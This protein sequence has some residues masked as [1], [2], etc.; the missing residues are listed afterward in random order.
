MISNHKKGQKTKRRVA[1]SPRRKPNEELETEEEDVITK[2][3]E[4]L[5]VKI[6]QDVLEITSLQAL[7]Q[8][9]LSYKAKVLRE[10]TLMTRQIQVLQVGV[11]GMVGK[12]S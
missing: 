9:S 11:D 10:L 1:T 2:A 5:A 6:K 8:T 4:T 7:F 3:I 12:G